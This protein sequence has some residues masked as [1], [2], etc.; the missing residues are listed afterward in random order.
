MASQARSGQ[1][2]GESSP[3]YTGAA[4]NAAADAWLLAEHE[5]QRTPF[6]DSHKKKMQ[7]A[8]QLL[9]ERYHG[10]LPPERLWRFIAKYA[11]RRRK[12][13][14]VADLDGRGR[15]CQLTEADAR[16]ACDILLAGYVDR[17]GQRQPFTSLASALG[18]NA[19]LRR[20]KRRCKIRTNRTLWQRLTAF[21]RR[22][23][24]R[25][26]R[27]RAPLTAA[28]KQ[29]R[30]EAAAHIAA[31]IRAD[32]DWLKRVF[33]IDAKKMYIRPRRRKVIVNAESSTDYLCIPGVSWRKQDVRCV[34][35]YAVVN[36]FVGAVLFVVVSGTTDYS[37]PYKV[38]R[39][40]YHG[41]YTGCTFAHWAMAT[42]MQFSQLCSSLWCSLTTL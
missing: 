37:T 21:D 36:Y 41:E 30:R 6:K 9:R 23:A 20:I 3:R 19:E 38:R 2:R 15:K 29:K 33:W 35:Y 11:E 12:L 13:Q 8:C 18:M 22:L 5:L 42:L 40:K 24:L 17:H 32:P 34:F 25:A 26:V 7:R 4:R 31:R 10:A 27:V 16:T 39:C 1:R 28:Q 14:H